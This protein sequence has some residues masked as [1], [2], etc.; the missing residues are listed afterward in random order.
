MI[1]EIP[2][3][4]QTYKEG[5]APPQILADAFLYEPSD[6]EFVDV[7]FWAR[8]PDYDYIFGVPAQSSPKH[9]KEI[10]FYQFR[11]SRSNFPQLGHYCDI[12]ECEALIR[13]FTK[14]L[15]ASKINSLHLWDAHNHREQ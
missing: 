1:Y 10:G 12:T 6:G 9:G 8:Y 5:E 7:V 11:D 15:E 4:V 3:K 14:I 2:R 13:G